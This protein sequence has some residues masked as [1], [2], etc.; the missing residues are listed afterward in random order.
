MVKLKTC[1]TKGFGNGSETHLVLFRQNQDSS[2]HRC[3]A[4]TGNGDLK[5]D[6][7]E[8]GLQ[9]IVKLA[10]IELAPEKAEYHG[11][12]WH[13]EGQLVRPDLPSYAKVK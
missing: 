13:V 11:S 2:R 12:T 6:Y 5:R 9:V 7:R 1:T 10:N 4:I 3:R 8:R